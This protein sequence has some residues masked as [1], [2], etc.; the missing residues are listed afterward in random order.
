V[1]E[2]YVDFAVRHPSH[3]RVMF[4]PWP[5][6]SDC[7]PGVGSCGRDP[8]Q[9]LV[10][11]LDGLASAGVIG[12]R[13]RAGAEIVAWAAVHGLASLLVEGSLRLSARDRAAAVRRV[14]QN[15]LRG[16]GCDP[17]LAGSVEVVDT[18]PRKPERRPR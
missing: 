8:Y 15:V 6:E 12:A 16:L 10:D 1:G 11:A 9:I 4:G 5:Q 14:Q 17:E 18:D 7:A 3:F 2:A 13:S